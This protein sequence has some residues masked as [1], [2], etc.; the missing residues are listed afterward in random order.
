MSLWLLLDY[1][2]ARII[3]RDCLNKPHH[4]TWGAFS[5]MSFWLIRAVKTPDIPKQRED[6]ISPKLS[7]F[8]LPDFSNKAE[9][10]KFKIEQHYKRLETRRA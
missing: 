10:A 5:T 3:F 6:R 2:I 8:L 4:S 1:Q 7:E 9:A